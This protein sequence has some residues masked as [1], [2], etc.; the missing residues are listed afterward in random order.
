MKKFFKRLGIKQKLLMLFS[1]QIIIPMVFMGV[2]LYRNSTEIIQD[3]SI[4]YSVDILKMIELRF[5]DFSDNVAAAADDILYDPLTYAV[6]E[7]EQPSK[8]QEDMEGINNL[9]RKICLSND[10][11]Q[12]ISIISNDQEYYS[13]DVNTG[14]ASIE[15]RLAYDAIHEASIHAEGQMVWYVEEDAYKATSNVYVLRSIYNIDRYDELGLMVMHIKQDELASVYSDLSTEFM[16]RI[17]IVTQSGDYVVGTSEP[18]SENL[19]VLNELDETTISTYWIDEKNDALICYRDVVYPPWRI[20]TEISMSKLN[21]DMNAFSNYFLIISAIT[22]LILSLLSLFMSLDIIEPINKLV[23][24]M[25]HMKQDKVHDAIPV[26]RQDELGYLSECFND[27]S[28][29]ID[30]LLNQV[31]KEQLTRKEAELKT[32]QAQIN[33]HFLFN[34]LESINW[35]ARLNEVPE[36]SE[37]VTALSELMEAGIGK[38]GPKVSLREELAFVDSYIL[39]MKNRY[40]DRL[41]FEKAVDKTVLNRKVPKLMLQ[42]ILENAIYHGID[43]NR[44]N[45]EIKLSV[46]RVD[47]DIEIVVTDNGKGMTLDALNH[48]ND[49]L[50]NNEDSYL[51]RTSGNAAGIG[52]RNVNR[53]LKLFYGSEYGV[54]VD[55]EE[56]IFTKVVIRLPYDDMTAGGNHV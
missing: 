55:S 35:Q 53:R 13:Y 30:I 26:D 54:T 10:E 14:R 17:S 24:A 40:G 4:D 39:I 29:E 41:T 6:L 20:I 36:I 25:R 44:K 46:S 49:E 1:I 5:N 22:L 9:I 31:Y 21:K 28:E 12:A 2:M 19:A 56:G 7:N 45:G 48:L 18:S 8:R 32:L 42:P 15:H 16:E 33:P 38:G 34:T 37:M 43:K 47:K 3:K 27:M 51:E 11:I 23:A 50:L 52:L